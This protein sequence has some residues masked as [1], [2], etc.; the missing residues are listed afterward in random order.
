MY[1][2]VCLARY[3]PERQNLSADVTAWPTADRDLTA[4]I[5]T[6]WTFLERD[7][8]KTYTIRDP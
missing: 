2:L 4:D 7:H 1:N 5:K 6:G 8:S 3:R